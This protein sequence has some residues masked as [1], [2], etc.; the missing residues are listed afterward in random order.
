MIEPANKFRRVFLIHARVLAFL[1]LFKHIKEIEM[2]VDNVLAELQLAKP[3]R[4]ASLV[5]V[6]FIAVFGSMTTAQ[7]QAFDWLVNIDD[8]GFDPVLAGTIVEYNIRG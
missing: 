2:K 5:F 4:L 6:A 8:T 7:A 1:Q 3:K